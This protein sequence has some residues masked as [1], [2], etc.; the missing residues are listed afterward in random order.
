ML[1]RHQRTA[2]SLAKLITSLGLLVAIPEII[3]LIIGND[4]K[5][6]PP[7][8]WWV[9][10]TDQFLWPEG[11]RYVLDA[12]QIATLISTAI[13][14]VA[15]TLLFRGGGLGLRMRAVVESPRLVQLQGINS[16]RVSLMAWI[17]SSIL[18]GLAGVLI[19]P[20]SAQL[21]PLD[22]FTLLVAAIAACVFGNLTSIVM[23]FVGGLLLGILQAE[24]AGFL[25]TDS[26][27]AR[28]LRPSLPF[29]V[30]FV[31]VLVKQVGAVERRRARPAGRR[32]PTT[33]AAGGHASTALDD[34]RHQG[35]RGRGRRHRPVRQPRSC[36]TTTG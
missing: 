9:K 32:R 30:L 34:E 33:G 19:A 26:I 3:Q 27:V 2:G 10:R 29:A 18:A 16:E 6:N 35:V 20:L 24:L 14:V 7:A 13:V 25:P 28:G 17:L 36:S 11:S 15:L 4:A 23:T 1:Y 8:L 22:F 5:K 12:G 31:L 21:D